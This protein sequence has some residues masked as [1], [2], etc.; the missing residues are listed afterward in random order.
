MNT[1]LMSKDQK[2]YCQRSVTV[3][4]ESMNVESAPAGA[5]P[6]RPVST[7]RHGGVQALTTQGYARQ[8]ATARV[9]DADLRDEAARRFLTGRPGSDRQHPPG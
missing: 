3:M 6:P 2:T 5:A 9:L 4:V 8:A 1:R 7:V